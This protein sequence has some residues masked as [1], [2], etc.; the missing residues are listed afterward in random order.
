MLCRGE[1]RLI[2]RLDR[3]EVKLTLETPERRWL[4]VCGWLLC[5]TRLKRNRDPDSPLG[6]FI[7]VPS[8]PYRC[9]AQEPL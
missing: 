3:V 1:M 6:P 8:G 9:P 4:P 2:K 7:V 5:A